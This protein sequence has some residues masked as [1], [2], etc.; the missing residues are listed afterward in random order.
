MH[1]SKN[2]QTMSASNNTGESDAPQAEE[3]ARHRGGSTVWLHL[4]KAQPDQTNLWIQ[5]YV[6]TQ[7]LS[8]PNTIINATFAY[9]KSGCLFGGELLTRKEYRDDI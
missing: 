9:V 3:E 6:F 4:F 8:C 1:S 5:L 2:E 7:L